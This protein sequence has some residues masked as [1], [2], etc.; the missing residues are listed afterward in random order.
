MKR[1]LIIGSIISAFFLYLALKGIE[2]NVLWSVLRQ[3]RVAYLLP[4]VA[5][6]LA[7]HYFRAYRWKFMLLP[8][9]RISTGSLFIATMIGFMANN[10]LPA[11]LGEIVRA[12]TLGMREHISRTASF[13]T[14]V[15][16]RIIDVFS[17]LI[18]VWLLLTR[19]PGPDWLRRS[20]LWLL[21]ANIVFLAAMLVMERYR[22]LVTRLVAR[23]SRP[24]SVRVRTKIHRATEGYLGGLAGMT[25]VNTL[26]PIA[27]TSAPVWGFAMIG[28]YLCFRALGMDVPPVATVALVVLVAMGSMIPSAPAYLGTTQYACVVGLA[29]FGVGKSEALAFSILFHALQFFPVTALGLYYLWKS[30]IRLRDVSKGQVRARSV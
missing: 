27:L 10:L 4:V 28:I 6:S 17:L 14:I 19:I 21:A 13:A 15:Y 11:R 5:V 22:G 2:W 23:L 9:K 1:N 8:I 16:E 26:I 3:T 24:L 25:R 12:Y 18:L 29:L 30:Q 7:G 20:A